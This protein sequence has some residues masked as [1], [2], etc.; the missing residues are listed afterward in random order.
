M[1]TKPRVTGIGGVFYMAKIPAKLGE[2]YQKHLG[3]P[4]DP[5]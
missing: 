3:L 4:T 1:K 5:V 2:W